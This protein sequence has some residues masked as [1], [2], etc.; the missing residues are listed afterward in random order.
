MIGRDDGT[1]GRKNR[2]CLRWRKTACDKVGWA[3]L[4]GVCARVN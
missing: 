1:S 4:N 2:I 3:C